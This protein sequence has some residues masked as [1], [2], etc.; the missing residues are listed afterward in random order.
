[1]IAGDNPSASTTTFQSPLDIACWAVGLETPTLSAAWATA[2][3]VTLMRMTRSV[4]PLMGYSILKVAHL[5]ETRMATRHA[6][7][8]QDTQSDAA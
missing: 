2:D 4:V 3:S 8:A 6:A 1:M 5:A 7:T